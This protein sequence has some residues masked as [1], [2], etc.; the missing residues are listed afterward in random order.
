MFL[1]YVDESGD[2]G[3]L[4]AGSPTA[5]FILTGIVIH[6]LR[7]SE[8]LDNLL[9]FRQRM[10][11]AYGLRLRDEIHA[12][13]MLGR[14]APRY[15]HIRKHQRLA[16]VRAFAK[17]IGG[18]AGV[19]IINVVVRKA[20]KDPHYDIFEKAWQCLIQR[21][22]NTLAH[23][24]FTGPQNAEDLGLLIPDH[25]DDKKLIQL[26]RRMR[27]YNPVPNQAGFGPGYRNIQ[28]RRIAEDPNFR[29]SGDSLF[30]QMADTAAYL[31]RQRDS[32][33]TYMRRKGGVN[34][35]G[36]LDDALC[37]VASSTNPQGIVYL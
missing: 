14:S 20:A 27:R 32:P 22:E 26:L 9:A 3:S 31:L 29:D 17:Q 7:W 15:A 10:K 30:I 28:L 5:Q 24:N 6:E 16:I 12:S 4:A 18:M 34:Y 21:F 19:N 8:H 33:S 23:R 36:L 1:M 11:M 25:T 2:S 35:F 37:K 13:E